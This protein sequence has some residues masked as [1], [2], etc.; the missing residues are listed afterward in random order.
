M[1][2]KGLTKFFGRRRV[3]DHV[4]ITV[5]AGEIVGLLGKNG[6]GKTTT[7]RMIMGTLVPN[8]GQVFFCGEDIGHLPMYQRAR[9][10]L[11][12][13]S[14]ES[15]IF[16]TLTVED[17]IFALLEAR[18]IKG[19]E[20]HKITQQVL[21]E[22]GIWHLRKALAKGLSGGERKRL[23]VARVLAFQPKLVLLDEPFAAV[24]PIARSEIKMI[25]EQLRVRGMG[26]LVTDHNE[27]EILSLANRTYIM[28]HGQILTQGTTAE[29]LRDE[30]ARRSY[31]GHD[32]QL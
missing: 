16:R 31:L 28:E 14:Q 30:Q 11:G 15:A 10:G 4:N 1:E 22:L 25:V 9:K 26:I 32:F 24:D 18:G 21:S 19:R 23:E 5:S 17:N 13:L 6:A 7:F 8:E 2:A 12:Y 29:L 3:V 20:G 27:R